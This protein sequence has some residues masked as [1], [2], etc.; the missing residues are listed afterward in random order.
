MQVH[1]EK[2]YIT[3]SNLLE[4]KINNNPNCKNTLIVVTLI[5]FCSKISCQ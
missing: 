4:N 1:K 3:L 5:F 2:L